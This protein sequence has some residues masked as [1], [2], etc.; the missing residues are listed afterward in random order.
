MLHRQISSAAL[1]RSRADRDT[2]FPILCLSKSYEYG[3]LRLLNG[4]TARQSQEWTNSLL[5]SGKSS[6]AKRLQRP[7]TRQAVPRPRPLSSQ[8]QNRKVLHLPYP[9][10]LPLQFP[11]P[12]PTSRSVLR[13]RAPVPMKNKLR[14]PITSQNLSIGNFPWPA[15]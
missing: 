9:V 12:S 14:T 15:V 6:F 13:A 8:A 4:Q 3:V 7:Q 11:S 10:C 2:S 5:P 1:R